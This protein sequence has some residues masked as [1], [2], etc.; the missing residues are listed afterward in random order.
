MPISRIDAKFLLWDTLELEAERQGRNL[1][2]DDQNR[3]LFSALF[4]W[5]SRTATKPDPKKGIAIL[6]AVGNGKS[7]A[8]RALQTAL[9]RIQS[10]RCFSIV[11]CNDVF[12]AVKSNSEATEKFKIG[13]RCFDDLGDENATAVNYG[14]RIEVMSGILNARY[15]KFESDPNFY[16]HFTSNLNFEEIENQYGTRTADRLIQMCNIVIL[17][18]GSR[19]K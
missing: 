18:G 19:R 1:E 16:T 10:N 12:E 9:G 3:Q 6:G 14:N 7:M 2:V 8:M 13:N 4:G 11:D 17:P 15:R 5:L